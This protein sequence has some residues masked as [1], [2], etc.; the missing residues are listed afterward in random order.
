M[1]S[2]DC[3]PPMTRVSV[4]S[5]PGRSVMSVPPWTGSSILQI[6][7]FW[8]II[9]L[10]FGVCQ[11]KGRNERST[12]DHLVCST[13]S[14]SSAPLVHLRAGPATSSLLPIR[15]APGRERHLP[16]SEAA[17]LDGT[18]RGQ[19]GIYRKEGPNRLLDHQRRQRSATRVAGN[20]NLSIFDGLRGDAARLRRSPRNQ[21][22]DPRH[23][24]TG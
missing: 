4:C 11:E 16:G 23:A 1:T 15:L 7:V 2:P 17:L 19:K 3:P 22:R 24:R 5:L 21:R 18:D 9:I 6:G 14:G 13:G 10:Q 8:S 12:D 20:S